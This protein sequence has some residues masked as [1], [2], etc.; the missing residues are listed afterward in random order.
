L[1]DAVRKEVA[2]QFTLLGVDAGTWIFLSDDKSEAAVVQLSSV[3]VQNPILGQLGKLAST[4]V[5][6]VSVAA[7]A[8][9]EEPRHEIFVSA[10]PSTPLP[11]KRALITETD[12]VAH[13]TSQIE[14]S[15]T[16]T[17]QPRTWLTAT[18]GAGVFAGKTVG[19]EQAKIDNGVY[20]GDPPP[21]GA[22]FAGVSIHY[23]FDG[24]RPKPSRAER[25]GVVVAAVLTPSVGI[26]VGPAYGWRGLALTAGWAEMWV[27]VPPSPKHINDPVE[28]HERLATDRSGRFLVSVS[29][30]FGG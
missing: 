10:S 16:Y 4:I 21:R 19:A 26:Y 8:A 9:P 28:D 17:N 25:W 29:Y 23:P 24:S 11:L 5:P 3:P 6:K 2:N 13:G 7:V 18:A 14:G 15:A 12:F 27:D 20:V 1:F 22:T 30:A